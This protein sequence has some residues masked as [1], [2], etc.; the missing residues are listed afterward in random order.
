MRL[1]NGKVFLNESLTRMNR[2]LF[3]LAR[4]RCSEAGW[5][6]TWTKKGVVLV[7]KNENTAPTRI[8]NIKE[9]EQIVK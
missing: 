7:R 3:R 1:K 4:L 9:L 5:K 8:A 2:E 6:F